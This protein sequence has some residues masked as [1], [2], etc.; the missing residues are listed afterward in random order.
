[1]L[2]KSWDRNNVNL[3]C[4]L[5]GMIFDSSGKSINRKVACSWGAAYSVLAKTRLKG[6][7]K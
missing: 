3:W 7:R 5:Q 2:I 4:F 6:A 1:M